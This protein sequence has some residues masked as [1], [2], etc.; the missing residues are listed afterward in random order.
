MS[1]TLISYHTRFNETNSQAGLMDNAKNEQ[2]FHHRDSPSRRAGF[3]QAGALFPKTTS[4][5]L[6]PKMRSKRM[7]GELTRIGLDRF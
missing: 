5:V 6:K 7:V 1:F 2:N 3:C 4:S